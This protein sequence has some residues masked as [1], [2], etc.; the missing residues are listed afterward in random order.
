MP[1]TLARVSEEKGLT[2]KDMDLLREQV[3]DIQLQFSSQESKNIMD[4]SLNVSVCPAV[5]NGVE[6]C[7]AFDN[8][9]RHN[10]E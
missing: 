4:N 3:K 10:V 6:S 2:Y 9:Y 8:Y 1:V 7:G 5:S